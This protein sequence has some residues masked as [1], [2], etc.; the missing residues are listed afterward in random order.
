MPEPVPASSEN[1]PPSASSAWRTLHLPWQTESTAPYQPAPEVR[2]W[3]E[4]GA[5]VWEIRAPLPLADRDTFKTAADGFTEGLW[6]QDVAECFI[7]ATATG[8]YTE[9]NLSPAG[10]WWACHYTAPRIRSEP[11]PVDW[12]Q[13]GIRAETDWTATHWLGRMVCPL[14]PFAAAG[15]GSGASGNPAALRHGLSV[16]FTAVIATATQREYF[17]LAPIGG[18]DRPNFHRLMGWLALG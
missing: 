3:L 6:T 11:Q 15:S 8:H 5:L 14:P 2:W 18:G 17:S 13:S 12:P 10:A 9:Y 7:A 16:N 1:T 4:N